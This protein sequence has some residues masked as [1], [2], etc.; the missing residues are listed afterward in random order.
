M[1]LRNILILLSM[2]FSLE[3]SAQEVIAQR[4]S[5]DRF[6][7]LLDSG[8]QCGNQGRYAEAEHYM[9]QA[10]ALH[11]KHPINAM[12]WNNVAALR[13]L[14]GRNEASIEAY[15]RALDMDQDNLIVRANRARLHALMGEHLKAITD[16]SILVASKPQ[17]E[18]YRYQRAMSYMLSKQ[19]D[20][21]DI[22]LS[23]LIEQN[24]STLKGR[25]GYALL[26][27]ARGRYTEAE[28]IYDYLVDKLP[29]NAEVYEGRARMYLARGM[30]GFAQR[31]IS[32]AFEY[33]GLVP[34]AELYRLRAQISRA[35]GDAKAALSDEQTASEIDRKGLQPR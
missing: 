35:L 13:Q 5:D 1:K 17:D 2:L 15:T 19:Y 27:T 14:L 20:L 29:K 18:L 4:E 12:L 30:M 23:Y 7:V 34:S 16:Y 33:A 22:D 24:P 26:E 9:L 8:F 25:I 32:K 28:R 10:I 3:L 21:A 11:P 31:D 6:A